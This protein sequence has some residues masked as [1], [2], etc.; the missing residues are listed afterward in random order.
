MPTA[1][2]PPTGGIA[3]NKRRPLTELGQCFRAFVQSYFTSIDTRY[4]DAQEPSAG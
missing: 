4:A 1:R 2:P 3:Y